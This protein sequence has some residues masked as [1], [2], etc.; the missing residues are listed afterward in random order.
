MDDYKRSIMYIIRNTISEFIWNNGCMTNK[1]MHCI[2][3]PHYIACTMALIAS[4]MYKDG[5]Y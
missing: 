2:C 1:H 5:Q 3:C 4:D